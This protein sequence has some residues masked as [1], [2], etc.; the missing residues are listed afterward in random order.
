MPLL[1]DFRWK[2]KYD[3]DDGSLVEQFY[4]AALACAQRYDRTT[5]YFSATALAIAARG[6][7][8]LVLN[9]DACAWSWAARWGNRRWTRSGRGSR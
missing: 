9:A 3:L 2:T 7:E 1:T 8:G 5:G 4:L 6:V